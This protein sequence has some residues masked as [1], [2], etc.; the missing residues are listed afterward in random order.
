MIVIS[1]LMGIGFDL[2]GMNAVKMLFWSAIL[3]GLLAP[4]LVVM[5]VLLTSDRKVMGGKT[6]SKT[7]SA[8]GWLCALIMGG[9]ALG[10]LLT[11]EYGTTPLQY[12]EGRRIASNL[13]RSRVPGVVLMGRKPGADYSQT[14]ML[15][16]AAPS[17]NFELAI[18]VAVSVFGI[19][20]G[21]A[22]AAV[23]APL[24]EVPEMI[25]LINLPQFFAVGTSCFRP[26]A[27][28]P[29]LQIM[30]NRQ[31]THRARHRVLVE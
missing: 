22:F 12:G 15:S 4:P 26:Q 7:M 24:V 23:I 27:S 20:T 5:I 25:A 19:N 10:L 28:S 6:N 29:L 16:L 3:N 1:V 30:N 2:S 11:I 31:C 18:A 14:A 13:F 8:L 9:A 17:N 21:A